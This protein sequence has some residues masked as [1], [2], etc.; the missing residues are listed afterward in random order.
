MTPNNCI[1]NNKTTEGIQDMIWAF[2][3]SFIHDY[4]NNKQWINQIATKLNDD[5]TNFGKGGTSLSYSYVKFNEIRNDIKKKDTIVWVTT[6]IE[7]KWFDVN[8]PTSAVTFVRPDS[9]HIGKAMLGYLKYLHNPIVDENDFLNFLYNLEYITDKKKLNTIIIPAFPSTEILL[10]K[11][12]N[13]FQLLNIA[14]GNLFDIQRN[15]YQ[16]GVF[17]HFKDQKMKDKKPNHMLKVNHN[18]LAKKIVDSIKLGKHI[19]LTKNFIE[20]VI[21]KEDLTNEN[22]WLLN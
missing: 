13:D 20:N 22:I 10:N 12:R 19:N 16:S 6:E 2:G 7:R 3:D 17:M 1:Y 4:K 9:S 21:N 8:D 14:K 15:E 18:K 11:Y 5:I